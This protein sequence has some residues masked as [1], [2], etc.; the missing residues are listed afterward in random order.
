MIIKHAKFLVLWLLA[1]TY[2][3]A[4]ARELKVVEEWTFSSLKGINTYFAAYKNPKDKSPTTEEQRAAIRRAMIDNSSNSNIPLLAEP[5]RME[6]SI[7]NP[8]KVTLGLF[9]DSRGEPE[10]PK[11]IARIRYDDAMGGGD[12]QYM[13]WR[14]T[15]MDTYVMISDKA[16]CIYT[17]HRN[18]RHPDGGNLLTFVTIRNTVLGVSSYCMVGSARKDK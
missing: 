7:S 17:V 11:G 8:S 1:L 13:V 3:S 2:T 12:D 5:A 14:T 15:F 18:V 16:T 6:D 4:S 9:D 10:Q